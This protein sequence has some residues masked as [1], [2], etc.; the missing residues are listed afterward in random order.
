M[1]NIDRNP[2]S[3]EGV[4]CIACHRVNRAYGKLSGRLSIVEGDLTE[5]IYGPS[6]DNAELERII[7]DIASLAVKLRKPLTA[8]LIPVPGKRAGQRTEFHNPLLTDVK[9]QPLH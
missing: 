9:L 2:T 5:P 3:R 6:G 4:T 1:S 7:G 8:R